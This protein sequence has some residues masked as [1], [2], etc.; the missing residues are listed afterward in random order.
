RGRYRNFS[1]LD[2]RAVPPSSGQQRPAPVR[3]DSK[4][5][6]IEPRILAKPVEAVVHPHER[7][8]HRLFG[9]LIVRQH[10]SCETKAPRIVEV[11]DL[12]EGLLFTAFRP[13]WNRSIDLVQRLSIGLRCLP[14][15]TTLGSRTPPPTCPKPMTRA[16]FTSTRVWP[17]GV[18]KMAYFCANS[19]LATTADE[20]PP[21][22]HP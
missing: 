14:Q 19:G 11:H 13:D 8:L 7:I 5:P 22:E 6:R 20:P 16:S 15:I 2:Q 17:C 3:Q 12:D 4:E 18:T 1:V 21:Q 9:I 10:I